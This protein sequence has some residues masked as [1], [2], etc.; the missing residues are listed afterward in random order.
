MQRST[1]RPEPLEGKDLQE[2]PGHDERAAVP[3]QRAERAEQ[4]LEQPRVR[5]A[6]EPELVGDLQH[7]HGLG[8]PVEV[9][10]D[11]AEVIEGLGLVD[12]VQL[13]APLVELELEVGGR[14]E[15]GAEAALGL[16]DALRHRSHLPVVRGEDADDPVGLAELVGAEH[17]ALC[18]VQAHRLHRT[19]G[20]VTRCGGRWR[21]RP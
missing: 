15:P 3:G 6:L 8:E 10:A 4:H 21:R 5:L 11:R 12:D 13:A 20:R 2:E 18:P 17:D 19:D 16:A 1:T 9:F 7:R 14:L